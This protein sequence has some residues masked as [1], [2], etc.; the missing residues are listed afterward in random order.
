M[1]DDENGNDDKSLQDISEADMLV[2]FMDLMSQKGISD[3]KPA[4]FSIM[5][6]AL[7]RRGVRIDC[8]WSR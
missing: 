4:R 1:H 6:S 5:S 3:Y 2:E 8:V 7:F